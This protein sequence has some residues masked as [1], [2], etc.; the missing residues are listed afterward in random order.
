LALADLLQRNRP[1]GR[2][3]ANALWNLVMPSRRQFEFVFCILA[4][5]TVAGAARAQE[6]TQV[7]RDACKPDVYRLCKWY[8]PSHDG[9]TYCLHQNVDKLSSKCRD[10]IEGRLR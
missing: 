8:I 9:I 6:S 1:V 5:L 2:F 3:Q 4:A 10:V 7:Q